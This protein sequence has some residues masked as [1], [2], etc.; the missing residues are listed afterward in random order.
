MFQETS[1]VMPV[2][3]V[4]KNSIKT[5]VQILPYRETIYI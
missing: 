1:E 5:Q 4:N 3:T 2:N